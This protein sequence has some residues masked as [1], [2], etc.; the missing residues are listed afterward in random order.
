MILLCETAK[1]R[2]SPN[3]YASSGGA[4]SSFKF[5]ASMDGAI[6]SSKGLLGVSLGRSSL[7]SLVW[8]SENSSYNIKID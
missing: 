5:I 1:E 7:S 4:E 2:K 8:E 3:T 6:T